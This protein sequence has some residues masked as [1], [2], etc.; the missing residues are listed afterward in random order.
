MFHKVRFNSRNG[1]TAGL[2]LTTAQTKLPI[3]EISRMFVHSESAKMAK[4]QISKPY[5]TWEQAFAH[6]FEGGE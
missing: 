6:K 2:V 5:E 3:A 4:I 1:C